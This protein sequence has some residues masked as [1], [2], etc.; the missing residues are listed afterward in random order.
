[1]GWLTDALFGNDEGDG[2]QWPLAAKA[3]DG[4]DQLVGNPR[5][6]DDE[7]EE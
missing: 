7:D 1:M 5:P 2:P 6:A 4:W 3:W